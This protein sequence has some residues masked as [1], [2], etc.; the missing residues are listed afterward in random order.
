MTL[1]PRCRPSSAIPR[2]TMPEPATAISARSGAG[3][4][5]V[6]AS[7]SLLQDREAIGET[8]L[9]RKVHL[10]LKQG[11]KGTLSERDVA[12]ARTQFTCTVRS[13]TLHQELADELRRRI[14]DGE[15]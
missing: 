12:I 8:K 1:R 5:V 4:V 10:P 7:P 6:T 3:H 13:V 9:S 15:I 11:V 2:P 14:L